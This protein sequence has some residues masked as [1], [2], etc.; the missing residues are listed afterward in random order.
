MD[1][2]LPNKNAFYEARMAGWIAIRRV[3]LILT[4]ENLIFLKFLIS[5]T[6]VAIGICKLLL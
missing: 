3:A 1:S 2:Y 4:G 5:T 6:A